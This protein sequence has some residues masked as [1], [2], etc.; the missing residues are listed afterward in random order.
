MRVQA[1]RGV[2]AIT[3]RGKGRE[4]KGDALSLIKYSSDRAVRCYPHACAG[5]SHRQF[6]EVENPSESGFQIITVP[7]DDSVT[8]ACTF[9]SCLQQSNHVGRVCKFVLIAS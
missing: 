6:R 1:R 2:D 7:Y 3:N 8:Y 4:G 9:W 5:R